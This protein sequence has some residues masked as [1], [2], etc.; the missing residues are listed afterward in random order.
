[1]KV[2]AEVVVVEAHDGDHVGGLARDRD[3]PMLFRDGR[4]IAPQGG[5]GAPA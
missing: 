4:L 2:A 3:H 1:M 5:W